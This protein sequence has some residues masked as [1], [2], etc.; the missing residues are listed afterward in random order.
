MMIVF[1]LLFFVLGL[2]LSPL[3][4][5]K[6]SELNRKAAAF[7]SLLFNALTKCKVPLR[8]FCL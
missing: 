3:S 8:V 7:A 1:G 6:P 4:L 2:N 5:T